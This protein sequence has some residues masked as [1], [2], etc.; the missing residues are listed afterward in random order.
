[1]LVGGHK[2][3]LGYQVSPLGELGERQYVQYT[4]FF[5]FGMTI[6]TWQGWRGCMAAAH[7]WHSIS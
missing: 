1:M 2:V 3:N 7:V 6:W 4:I 5:L